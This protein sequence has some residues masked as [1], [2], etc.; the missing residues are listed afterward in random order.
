MHMMLSEIPKKAI[1]YIHDI[2]R[3]QKKINKQLRNLRSVETNVIEGFQAELRH[4]SI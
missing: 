2:R 4:S 3:N 1:I